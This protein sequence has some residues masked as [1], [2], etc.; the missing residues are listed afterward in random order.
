ML[1]GLIRVSSSAKHWK[2]EFGFHGRRRSDFALE[3]E[4]LRRSGDGC[5]C[6]APQRIDQFIQLV[7]DR[8]HLVLLRRVVIDR[9]AE[10]ADAVAVVAG[11]GDGGIELRLQVGDLCGLGGDLLQPRCAT[12]TGGS[13]DIGADG[14]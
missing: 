4:A 9:Q 11:S 2:E 7:R 3:G 8:L 1:S 14:N 5:G 12:K 6:L 13:P 10:V